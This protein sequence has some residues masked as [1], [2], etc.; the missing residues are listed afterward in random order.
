ML[1][2]RKELYWLIYHRIRPTSI[3]FVRGHSGPSAD[4]LAFPT[5]T[6]TF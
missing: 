4:S 2:L 1:A 6:K 3:Q 5:K